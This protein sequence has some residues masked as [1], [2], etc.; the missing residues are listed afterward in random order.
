MTRYSLLY[1][2]ARTIPSGC[3]P[4]EISGKRGLF[5]LAAI[6]TTMLIG[7]S[8]V[9][10]HAHVWYTSFAARNV[11][12]CCYWCRS[13]LRLSGAVMWYNQ[14]SRPSRPVVVRVLAP[15]LESLNSLCCKSLW[16]TTRYLVYLCWRRC[17]GH[18][19][20]SLS[21][22]VKHIMTHFSVEAG[23]QCCVVARR[24]QGWQP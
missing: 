15:W 4:N 6:L 20:N 21:N 11:A 7:L 13:W 12:S 23:V 14:L 5:R 3:H 16:L 17:F 8:V 24:I 2:S 18:Q 1:G 9:T 22:S 10:A 19:D